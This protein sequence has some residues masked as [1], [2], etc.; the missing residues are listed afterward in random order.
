ML[1]CALTL[2]RQKQAKGTLFLSELDKYVCVGPPWIVPIQRRLDAF[3][4]VQNVMARG[5][6]L[7]GAIASAV[8]RAANLEARHGN[9]VPCISGGC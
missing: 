7:G 5:W 1:T 9:N 3:G 4:A 2:S 6:G 8:V